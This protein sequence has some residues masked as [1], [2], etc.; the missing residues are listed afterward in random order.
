M[1]KK[2]LPLILIFFLA[3]CAK[4]P[5]QSIVLADA[6]K[7][8]GLRM[9]KINL[10]MINNIFDSKKKDVNEF[11]ENTYTPAYLENFKKILPV[12]TDYK[13]EFN[14]IFQAALPEINLAK[15]SL[16]NALED[17]RKK[18]I[19]KLNEDYKVFEN[20]TDELNKL[21]SSAVNLNASR[22]DI[23][24]QAKT[25]SKGKIDI[26]AVESALEKFLQKG[27]DVSKNIIALDKDMDSIIKS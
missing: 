11:I 20:A 4:I 21:L 12:T 27:G 17:Q 2:V 6:I 14:D 13:K 23:Y 18:I 10:A 9:H 7:E 19:N 22:Q 15:D 5:V 16:L 8:E 1:R 26:S 24:N 3:A 25:L